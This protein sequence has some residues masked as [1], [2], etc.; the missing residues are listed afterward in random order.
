MEVLHGN[1]QGRLFASPS[2]CDKGRRAGVASPSRTNQCDED[3]RHY[4]A[5]HRNRI[6]GFYGAIVFFS[7]C[8]FTPFLWLKSFSPQELFLNKDSMYHS[9]EVFKLDYAEMER[10]FKVF[11]YPDGD[12]KTYYQT[13]RKL[14]GKYASEG[15]FFKNI[16]ESVFLTNDSDKAHLFFIPISCH[17]MRG[18]GANYKSMRSTVKNYVEGLMNKYPYWNRTLG[19]DHFFVACHEIGVKATEGVPLLVKNSIRVVCS[20]RYDT[21][22]I[23]HKDVALPQALHPFAHLPAAKYDLINRSRLAF[24]AGYRNSKVR[25]EL[26]SAWENDKEFDIQNT[27]I[28]TRNGSALVS[29]IFKFKTSKFCICPAGAH[30]NTVCIVNSIHYGCVPVMLSDYY[31]LPFNDV[32][33][34]TKFAVILKEADVFQIKHILKAISTSKFRELHTNT[35]KARKHFQWHSPPT[36]YDA[37][38]MVMYELWLRHYLVK[39]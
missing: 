38:H 26:T 4:A 24:W 37:F 3:E 14:S 35:I 17:K 2:L 39:Y 18:K 16:K 19:A 10:D 1:T 32:L 23:P 29:L 15:Y 31:D 33:D 27:H 12:P 34:W 25:E 8:Y 5:G 9:E 22:Y 7:L 11:V 36:K 6:I 21:G 30:A 20:P 28:D 13:P